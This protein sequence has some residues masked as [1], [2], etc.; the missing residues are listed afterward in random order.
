[1]LKSY[2][3]Y[4]I[5]F[6][7]LVIFSYFYI[8]KSITHTSTTPLYRTIFKRAK[9]NNYAVYQKSFISLRANRLILNFSLI[10]VVLDTY[11]S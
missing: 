7:S 10:K 2:Y 6:I 1:M 4:T 5:I 8:I 3:K 11:K 9:S